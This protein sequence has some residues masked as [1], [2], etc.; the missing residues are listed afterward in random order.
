MQDYYSIKPELLKFPATVYQYASAEVG[1]EHILKNRT[2]KFSPPAL[3]N[4]PLEG[5]ENLIDV[6]PTSEAI[7]KYASL[8]RV[9]GAPSEAYISKDIL[10][11]PREFKLRV[12]KQFEN[13]RHTV[14]IRSF[15]D[16]YSGDLMW[17][18]YAEKHTG[19]CVGFKTH[20][21]QQFF[22]EK[23]ITLSRVIYSDAFQPINY[24]SNPKELI[25]NFF[26]TKKN[27]YQY[28]GEIRAWSDKSEV[29]NFGA[30]IL[31]EVIIGCKASDSQIAAIKQIKSLPEY[32]HIKIF[33]ANYSNANL[34]RMEL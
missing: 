33:K 15:C 4:D 28:E 23:L 30:E 2:L 16:N 8:S 22:Y 32:N 12:I 3:L 26:H 13:L 7:N 10:K 6:V 19:I 27:D 18:H 25:F 11:D 17:T 14:G 31:D 34:L 1:I 21:L 9:W 24:L 20:E 29:L 5:P